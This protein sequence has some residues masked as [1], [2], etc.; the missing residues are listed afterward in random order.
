MK[1][2]ITAIRKL[3]EDAP[4]SYVRPKYRP[5]GTNVEIAKA[6]R[7]ELN[8][9]A[10]KAAMVE[11]KTM[12]AKW[13]AENERLRAEREAFEREIDE[14]FEELEEPIPLTRK[15]LR[16]K[17][18]KAPASVAVTCIQKLAPKLVIK[19]FMTGSVML[20]VKG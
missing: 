9:L 3:T 2:D 8:D 16:S 17:V 20:L 18:F 15:V 11:L 6:I 1:H 4:I 14:A 7:Q 19:R 10:L 5:S 13:Q 12:S